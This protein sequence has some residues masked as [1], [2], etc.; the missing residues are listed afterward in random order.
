MKLFK[1]LRRNLR[2]ASDSASKLLKLDEEIKKLSPRV[3]EQGGRLKELR[4]ATVQQENDT[5]QLVRST[6]SL[7]VLCGRLAVQSLATKP[8]GTSFA[9]VE[10][11][12]FSQWG[13]D[14]I[15]QHLIHHLKP[16]QKTFVEFGVETYVEASTRFL[17]INDNWRGLIIDG[18]ED[19]IRCITQSE[20]YWKHDLTAVASF[21]TP[22]NINQLIEAQKFGPRLGIL[23]VDIDGMDY[24][25]LKA[26]TARAD[27]LI[28][29]YN[30]VFGPTA[31]VTVPPDDAFQRSAAHH[32]NLFYGMS[33][34][35]AADIADQQGYDLVGVNSAGNNAFFVNRDIA[36]PFSPRR[37]EECFVAAKFREARDEKGD[38]TF[39]DFEAR[40]RA[41]GE[42]AAYDLT[43]QSVR[44]LREILGA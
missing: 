37:A 10:F 39:L 28:T 9:E 16:A 4:S 38:L 13:E 41:I 8:A 3:K 18:S 33:L 36:S 23:S 40:Q 19:N 21:I 30:S 26:I 17:L 11:K 34:A 32:S 29:E 14:G 5:R 12:V 27:I 2:L 1:N 44:P 42:C 22:A 35:A 20:L 43:T 31:K 7:Q 15:I 24:W 25:V 6:E